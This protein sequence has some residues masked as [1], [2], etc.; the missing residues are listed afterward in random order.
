MNGLDIF[1]VVLIALG[2]VLGAY[3]GL[4]RQ[5]LSIVGLI[6]GIAIAG[7][8]YQSVAD[9]LSSITPTAPDLLNLIAFVLVMVLVSLV[10]SVIATILR[11]F[12][13][14]LFLGWLDHLL[15]ALLG[16]L[17]SSLVL[18]ALLAALVAFPSV[19][20]TDQVAG[21]RLAPVLGRPVL[22][23]L[24]LMPDRFRPLNELTF[25]AALGFP[26]LWLQRGGPISE[27]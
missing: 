14:L 1:I 16:F 24:P 19:G 23:S 27:R 15:G 4:I 10:V 20:L 8:S 5:L 6:A 26:S 12:V 3:W 7:R 9:V 25:G 21:S 11:L 22:W 17:Q 2:T 13:G 18:A